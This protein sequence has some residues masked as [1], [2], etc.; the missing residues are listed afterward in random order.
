MKVAI[1]G[2]GIA[3]T[4]LSSL[5]AEKGYTNLLFDHLAPYEK[6]CGGGITSKTI[7]EFPFLDSQEIAKKVI[8]TIEF[9]SPRGRSYTF[10]LT[11][12]FYV[13][14][15]KELSRFLIDRARQLGANFTPEKVVRVERTKIGWQVI[16]DKGSYSA[17]LLVG[18]DGVKS[19]IRRWLW[20]NF[21]P[22]DLNLTVV[23]Y[24]K[25]DFEGRVK[26]R[27]LSG[28]EGY[29]W[30][31]PRSD[32]ASVGISSPLGQ[33]QSKQ[34]ETLLR[35]FISEYLPSRG[36]E[37]V[38]FKWALVPSL[39]AKEFSR[40]RFSGDSWALV[41]D[42]AGLVDPITGEGIYYALK[43]AQLL[44][45]AIL[46]EKLGDYYMMLEAEFLGELQ[47][48][49]RLRRRIYSPWF[50][51]TGLRMASSSRY[52]REIALPLFLEKPAYTRLKKRLLWKGIPGAAQSIWYYLTKP[53]KRKDYIR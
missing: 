25:G 6:P 33:M 23:S 8:H 35:E 43:S 10:S 13:F 39:K 32:Q 46:R 31:F 15:R 18:A 19:L 22:R 49:A 11:T 5:L 44:A 24:I 12:P 45:E 30:W 2:A 48:A 9:V 27:F 4:Y 1:V 26:V 29:I 42:A 20:K 16:S 51:E 52:F 53:L 47:K 36:T 14:S 28:V 3:G 7:R 50:L 41:G 37:A 38:S 34:L 17:D 40:Q 21:D